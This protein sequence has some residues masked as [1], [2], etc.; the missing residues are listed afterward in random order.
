[1]NQKA[2]LIV[3]VQLQVIKPSNPYIIQVV[4]LLFIIY[5]IIINI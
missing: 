1:M 3:M 5:H 2:C 4:F